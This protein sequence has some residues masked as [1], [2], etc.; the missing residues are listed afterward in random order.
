MSVHVPVLDSDIQ[1][2]EQSILFFV[3]SPLNIPLWDY[4]ALP[5]HSCIAQPLL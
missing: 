5:L 3:P 4:C 1:S 2:M